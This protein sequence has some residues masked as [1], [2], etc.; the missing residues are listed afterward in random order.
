MT[1]LVSLFH[2]K[3]HNILLLTQSPPMFFECLLQFRVRE[4]FHFLILC[5]PKFSTLLYLKLLGKYL[6][7]PQTNGMDTSPAPTHINFAKTPYERT[8]SHTDLKFG[9]WHHSDNPNSDQPTPPPHPYFGK[10]FISSDFSK[11]GHF[12]G[13]PKKKLFFHGFFQKWPF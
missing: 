13:V 6:S 4:C 3:E 1:D 9:M 11:N 8:D 5:L 12:R 2:S 7:T 10:N